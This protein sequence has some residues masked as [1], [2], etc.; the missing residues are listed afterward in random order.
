MK[1]VSLYKDDNSVSS[2]S[3]IKDVKIHRKM[4]SE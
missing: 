4:F 1:S 3:F 2:N